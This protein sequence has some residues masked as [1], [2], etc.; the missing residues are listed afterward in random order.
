MFA[1]RND[2]YGHNWSR[3]VLPVLVA[4]LSI[5]KHLLYCMRCRTLDG[6]ERYDWLIDWLV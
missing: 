1:G 3:W 6:H 2:A 5:F 4:A